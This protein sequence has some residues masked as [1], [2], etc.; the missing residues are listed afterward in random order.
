[1]PPGR[2]A[3]RSSHCRHG[4]AD[5]TQVS[6]HRP[7]P[8]TVARFGGVDADDN[9]G[10]NPCGPA[11]VRCPAA[12]RLEYPPSGH[13]A[14]RGKGT[15]ILRSAGHVGH[16]PYG[17]HVDTSSLGTAPT[18]H[19]RPAEGS[20]HSPRTTW[21]GDPTP[22]EEEEGPADISNR[23]RHPPGRDPCPSEVHPIAAGFFT[24]VESGAVSHVVLD[25]EPDGRELRPGGRQALQSSGRCW[26]SPRLP[27]GRSARAPRT[28]CYSAAPE[29]FSTSGAG[30]LTNANRGADGSTASSRGS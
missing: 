29:S 6:C 23:H 5:H 13:A 9:A 30:P 16:E 26:W 2:S 19:P 11:R 3:T 24:M 22:Q 27:E 25:A 7:R 8:A 1:M 28:R 20:P 4:R 12:E 14:A 17:H 10:T 15:S 21:I 18:W